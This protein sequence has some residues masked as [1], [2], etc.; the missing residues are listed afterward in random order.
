M[1]QEKGLGA[2]TLSIGPLGLES[3]AQSLE[4]WDKYSTIILLKTS[5]RNAV[6]KSI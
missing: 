6:E 5:V 4:G 2:V 3:L 1:I